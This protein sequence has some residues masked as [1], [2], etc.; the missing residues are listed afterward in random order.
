MLNLTSPWDPK[1]LWWLEKSLMYSG[2]QL[3]ENTHPSPYD[4]WLRMSPCLPITKWDTGSPN[5]HSL[6]AKC[7]AKQLL[8]ST[9]QSGNHTQF[10][11]FFHLFTLSYKRNTF[12]GLTLMTRTSYSVSVS[13]METSPLLGAVILWNIVS[14]YLGPDLFLIFHLL[15]KKQMYWR[16]ASIPFLLDS[17]LLCR[18]SRICFGH[19]DPWIN[20]A[21][22]FSLNFLL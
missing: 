6:P 14:S 1:I 10:L 19:L 9:D 15:K 21:T 4:R 5:S 22:L 16:K 13:P 11:T 7:S 18:R 3:P 2:T 8:Q 17:V 20:P 12:F